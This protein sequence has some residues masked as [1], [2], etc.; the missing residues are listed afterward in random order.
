MS[1]LSFQSSRFGTVEVPAE[2]VI[3]FPQGLIGLGGRHYA[4]V[5]GDGAF[6]WLH[7]VEDPSLAVPVTSPWQ[8]FADYAVELS[9]EESGRI[10]VEDPSDVTVLVTVRAGSTP[11]AVSANLR[12]PILVA[13]GC[14]HQ[15]INEL[16]DAP[17][18]AALFPDFAA[19]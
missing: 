7:S 19:A 5:A 1:N 8:F 16:S 17:V 6:S 13:G 14:G 12:A 4:L 10:G 18:R 9:D 3:D 11:D 2:E 15:V